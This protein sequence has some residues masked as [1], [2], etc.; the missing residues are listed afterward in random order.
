MTRCEGESG[1][2]GRERGRGRGRGC[3]GGRDQREGETN[4]YEKEVIQT[5][6]G[7]DRGRGERVGG[8]GG[9]RGLIHPWEEQ[10][11]GRGI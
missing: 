8:R 10:H 4:W 5:D 11:Y 3:K 2:R 7:G 1:V 9:G 6:G